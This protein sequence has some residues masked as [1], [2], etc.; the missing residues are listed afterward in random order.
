MR[1]KIEIRV[2]EKV[3]HI[4]EFASIDLFAAKKS[5]NRIIREHLVDFDNDQFP[6]LEFTIKFNKEEK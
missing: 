5:V 4:F 3:T 1:T 6:M 2:E